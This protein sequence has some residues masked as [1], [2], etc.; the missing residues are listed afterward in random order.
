MSLSR[1]S[2]YSKGIVN[3][4]MDNIIN[5]YSKE[6]IISLLSYGQVKE[7][8]RK[9]NENHKKKLYE[10]EIFKFLKKINNPEK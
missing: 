1:D 7:L 9:S 10:L 2:M 5:D 8:E 6:E 3:N 4:I